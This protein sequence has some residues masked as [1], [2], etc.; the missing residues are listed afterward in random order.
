MLALRRTLE[1]WGGTRAM[2]ASGIP[3]CAWPVRIG[4]I[5]P[6]SGW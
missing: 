1:D 6:I 5:A 2:L 4:S 3:G